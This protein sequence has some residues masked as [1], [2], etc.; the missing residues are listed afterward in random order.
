MR[1]LLVSLLVV[2]AV[3]LVASDP[4]G[5]PGE[6]APFS[7][8]TALGGVPAGP[9]AVDPPGALGA[10][11]PGGAAAQ[12]PLLAQGQPGIGPATPVPSNPR[13]PLPSSAGSSSQPPALNSRSAPR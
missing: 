12:G 6:A 11:G 8:T 10:P 13:V 7:S 2:L 4:P 3:L 1:S 9:L 5:R